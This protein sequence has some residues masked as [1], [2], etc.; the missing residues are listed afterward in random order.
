MVKIREKTK[1]K[2]QEKNLIVMAK[3]SLIFPLPVFPQIALKHVKW[4]INFKR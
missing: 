4:F 3:S 2:G 1:G